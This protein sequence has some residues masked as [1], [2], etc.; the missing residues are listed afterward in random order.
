VLQGLLDRSTV[1]KPHPP[2]RLWDEGGFKQAI[3]LVY[4]DTRA[5]VPGAA[6][7][8][9]A[10]QAALNSKLEPGSITVGQDDFWAR[11]EAAKESQRMD[12]NWRTSK[13][14][15]RPTH[16]RPEG[17]PGPGKLARVA[18]VS[19][20]GA[21][22]CMFEWTRKKRSESWRDDAALLPCTVTVPASKLL[23]VSAYKPGDF[24]KFF[25]D[26]RT[27]ADYLEWA[28]MLLEAEEY[29]AGNRE[30]R[31]PVKTKR[32]EP[33]LSG[34]WRYKKRKARAALAGKAV[35]LKRDIWTGSGTKYDKGS[36]WRAGKPDHR[37]RFWL[38][39]IGENGR[40]LRDEEGNSQRFV[41]GVEIGTLEI[42][43]TVPNEPMADEDS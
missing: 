13:R 42:D 11:R 9:L 26:P 19:G 7:D 31:E 32:A 20:K 17:D 15:W 41:T 33:S 8:F 37:G 10:Y 3:A 16:H 38:V 22:R 18:R 23:N 40:V 36:L 35:R 24:H 12:N 34:K 21:P 43:L 25:D 39:G 14:D 28:P 6:P 29:H 27:R 30:V 5:L 2:W 4:D 1:F